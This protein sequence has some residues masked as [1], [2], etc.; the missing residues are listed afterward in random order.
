MGQQLWALPLYEKG[1]LSAQVYLRAHPT[2]REDMAEWRRAFA[3]L[4]EASPVTARYLLL[5]AA[6]EVGLQCA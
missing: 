2:V 4:Y 1:C 3:A 6:S 5:V